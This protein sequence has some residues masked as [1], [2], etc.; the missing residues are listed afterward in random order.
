MEPEITE[1]GWTPVDLPKLQP[2]QYWSFS[3]ADL[4]N[5]KTYHP[6]FSEDP[7]CLTGLVES[8]MFSYQPTWDDCQQILQMLLTTEERERILLEA[9]KKYPGS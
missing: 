5:W 3:S 2:L 9:T 4:Y 8:L 1:Y 7:Q 6:P